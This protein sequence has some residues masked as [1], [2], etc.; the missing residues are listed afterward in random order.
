MALW[1][2]KTEA[3]DYSFSDLQKDGHVVWSGVAN[4]AALGHMRGTKKGDHVLIYHTG[5]E[6]RIIGLA[7]IAK[8]AYPDPKEKNEKLV[9]V[10]LKPVKPVKTPVTLVQLKA[11]ARFKDFLLVRISRLSVMPVPEPLAKILLKL[12]GLE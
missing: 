1:L 6:K 12:T 2:F 11:D 3:G 7:E 8:A 9:V 4:P 5:D 10:E